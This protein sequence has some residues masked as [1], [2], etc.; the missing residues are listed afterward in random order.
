MV[1]IGLS[2]TPM[3]GTSHKNQLK[4]YKSCL[5]YLDHLEKHWSFMKLGGLT[6]VLSIYVAL[7]LLLF[8]LLWTIL[9]INQC[10]GLEIDSV[11][12]GLQYG[13]SSSVFYLLK[14]YYLLAGK[15]TKRISTLILLKS[16][17]A[18]AQI[19]SI[20][21][22]LSYRL[23]APLP[24]LSLSLIPSLTPPSL[25]SLSCTQDFTYYTLQNHWSIIFHPQQVFLPT[26][27][28]TTK[29]Q[30]TLLS[31]IHNI[32]FDYPLCHIQYSSQTLPFLPC[33]FHWSMTLQ[34]YILALVVF[35]CTIYTRL[36]KIKDCSRSQITH[37]M[38]IYLARGITL[39]LITS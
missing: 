1:S 27:L 22:L 32:V 5:M 13:T 37:H 20:T 26:N 21:W 25:I 35:I 16:P 8:I 12:H 17:V 3:S 9:M 6:F 31:A 4:N 23:Q 14:M 18:T 36:I 2:T 34:I 15:S 11:A 33:Q 10:L 39:F 19:L 24:P 7:I 29:I 28:R 38:D 30:T